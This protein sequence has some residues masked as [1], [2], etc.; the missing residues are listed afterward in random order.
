M[1]S[2]K[3][4]ALKKAS[5]APTSEAFFKVEL[6]KIS[7][8]DGLLRTETRINPGI[9]V[10]CDLNMKGRLLFMA[11]VRVNPDILLWAADRSGKSEVIHGDFPNW[12]KWINNESQP[13]L[14]QLEKVAKVTSTPLGYFLLQKP[15]LEKL[16]IPHYRTIDDS[17]VSGP[18]PDLLETVQTLTRRQDWIRDSLIEQGLEPLHFIGAAKTS[19]NPKDVAKNIRKELGLEDGWAGKCRT[20]EDAFRMLLDKVENLR[21]FVVVN[22][23]V[24]NNTH[25]KLNVKE[26]RGF[27][28]V[29]NYAPFIFINGADGKAAQMFTL[30]HELAHIW[31]GVSAAF[32][33]QSLQPADNDIE[34]ACNF[35]AA[36]FLVPELELREFWKH[37]KSDG[38]RFQLI[39]R[40]FKVS[41]IVAA[42]RAL[43]LNLI[44]RDEFL[45]FYQNRFV[46][47]LQS[48]QNSSGG[49][50]YNTQ[51][52]RISRRFAEAV[53]R[54]TIEGKLMYREAYQL[55]GLRGKTFSEFAARLGFGGDV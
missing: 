40:R 42:R 14:K 28:L 45:D 49:N 38:E 9:F 39:S 7:D 27:V 18:S 46:N 43:D 54:S 33:L 23:V 8:G 35:V 1:L 37:I 25:R 34:E 36:E 24:G 10:S 11:R 19:H 6:F 30:A 20:W 29:D 16:S 55:T 53:I 3:E 52:F 21:I 51:A 48:N 32:D 47:L 17:H 50:F 5:D 26:F 12:L 41:E 15:P 2:Q 22:G 4:F 13:T 31:Y 44:N